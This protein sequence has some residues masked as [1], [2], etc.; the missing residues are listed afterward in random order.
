MV[1]EKNQDYPKELRKRG[2]IIE[3]LRKENEELKRR[4]AQFEKDSSTS[5]K[6]PSTNLVKITKNQ[7]L[8]KQTGK[9]S[10]G[11]LGQKRIGVSQSPTP[12]K[13]IP[14]EV[15]HCSCCGESL[16]NTPGSVKAK[17]QKKVKQKVSG[18]FRSKDGSEYYAAILSVIE[19][20]KKNSRNLLETIVQLLNGS[21]L[22]NYCS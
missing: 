21:L 8:R 15:A 13:I 19:T 4:I 2:T 6:P 5:S 14:C 18:Y 20:A 17:R 12:D 10:G 7:S 3:D 9:K 22:F 16:E 11:Q 1:E